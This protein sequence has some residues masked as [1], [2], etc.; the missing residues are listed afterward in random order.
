MSANPSSENLDSERELRYFDLISTLLDENKVRYEQQA[1]DLLV[2]RTIR[3]AFQESLGLYRL[4]RVGCRFLIS[5]DLG[6]TFTNSSW[7]RLGWRKKDRK[8]YL[9]AFFAQTEASAIFKDN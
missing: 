1:R 3:V 2:S 8:R 9:P 5:H 4:D 6:N 7:T